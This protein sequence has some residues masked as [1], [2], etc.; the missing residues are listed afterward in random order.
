MDKPAPGAVS[1]AV[2]KRAIDNL[3]AHQLVVQNALDTL[4]GSY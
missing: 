4:F 1:V 3:G 2:F